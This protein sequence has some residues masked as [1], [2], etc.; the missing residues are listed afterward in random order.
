MTVVVAVLAVRIL[1]VDIKNCFRDK[2]SSQVAY[3][4]ICSCF[5]VCFTQFLT[6]SLVHTADFRVT[7]SLSLH[8]TM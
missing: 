8:V 5:L 2:L 4:K 3:R 1:F 6:A 7:C